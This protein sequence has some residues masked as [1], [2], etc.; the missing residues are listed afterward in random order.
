MS[1]AA[2]GKY[3]V[4]VKRRVPLKKFDEGDDLSE[5]VDYIRHE[6]RKKNLMEKEVESGNEESLLS[7]KRF[8]M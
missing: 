4:K 6:L 7:E 3:D 1:S 5:Q 2:L 8:A